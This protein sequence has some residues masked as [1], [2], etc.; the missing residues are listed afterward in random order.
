MSSLALP[1][2]AE[3]VLAAMDVSAR[4]LSL[5]CANVAKAAD[6]GGALTR[7]TQDPASG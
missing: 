4:E 2:W 3:Q 1:V 5:V 6:V 7:C